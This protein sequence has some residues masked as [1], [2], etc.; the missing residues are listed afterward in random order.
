M[1][2][3][4]NKVIYFPHTFPGTPTPNFLGG[5]AHT[6]NSVDAGLFKIGDFGLTINRFLGGECT[7]LGLIGK[8]GFYACPDRG[9]KKILAFYVAD[10]KKVTDLGKQIIQERFPNYRIVYDQYL[11]PQEKDDI[12]PNRR[13]ELMK[14]FEEAGGNPIM[15]RAVS[16]KAILDLIKV[17]RSG[18]S[19]HKFAEASPSTFAP[20]ARE[21]EVTAIQT[22]KGVPPKRV[23]DAM[24]KTRQ[25]T[26]Q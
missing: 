16:S 14:Q 20:I 19:E 17:L 10:P 23:V 4:K 25:K 9:N 15:V 24:R 21:D 22:G 8:Y 7:H 11:V 2:D 18:T 1:T 13:A 3:E 5:E 12:D 6:F 26:T